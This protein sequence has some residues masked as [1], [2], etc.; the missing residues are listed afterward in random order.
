MRPQVHELLWK[1]RGNSLEGRAGSFLLLCLKSQKRKILLGL[2][3]L[4]VADLLALIPPWITKE[5]I[6]LISSG[7]ELLRILPLACGILIVAIFQAFFRYLWRTSLFGV[8]RDLEC[9]LR[10]KLLDHLLGLDTPF[11]TRHTVGD[12][13]SRC[14]ND[15]VAIQEMVAFSGLLI[16]D[17]SFTI[18]SCLVLMLLISPR[19]TFLALIPLPL[20][21]L[22]FMHFGKKVKI[23]ALQVQKELATLTE[24]VQ[25]TLSGIRV[26]KTYNIEPLRLDAYTKACSH[27]ME[28][29]MGLAGTRGAFYG[30]LGFLT[31]LAFVIVLGM[32]GKEVA[33][34]KLTLGEFVAL[35][36]YLAMLSWPMMSIGFMTNL[37]QRSRASWQRIREVLE[38]SP[39]MLSGPVSLGDLSLDV[40]FEDVSFMY[41]NSS[42]W[43]LR[44]INLSL[45][46][47]R[48]VGITG[49]VGSGKS[50]L[51]SLLLRIHDPQKGRILLGGVDLRELKLEDLRKRVA[52]VEQEPFLFSESI[53]E[54]ILPWNEMKESSRLEELVE[55]VSL[56]RDLRA[57]P[58][59][60]NTL[61]GERGVSLSGGQRQ[62]LAL[63]RALAMNPSILLLD[64][65]FSHLDPET[66]T[67]ILDRLLERIRGSTVVLVSQ[68][69]ATL[70]RADF[71]IVME[72]GRVVEE[73]EPSRLLKDKGYLAHLARAQEV[74]ELLGG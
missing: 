22:A 38:E 19:L 65:P 48:I 5:A 53:G 33:Q 57:F 28:S 17:S 10:G 68:R 70:L 18:G 21:S 72:K 8:A 51:L 62:R 25:E 35:S 55:M 24:L 23:R 66:E 43:A 36:A 9:D 32:G 30:V 37:V 41:P 15:L 44:D 59:G 45:S 13:M 27:Y 60:L 3:F 2:F 12:L 1:L 71:V 4:V 58:N 34:G 6:D 14:T 31:A 47:G 40:E 20:L 69:L 49:P 73:G 50:T 42:S 16:V 61:V 56:S 7:V 67:L 54:N 64:D 11:Y 46:Q 39:K 74:L 26:A 29:Q 63:A 52:I